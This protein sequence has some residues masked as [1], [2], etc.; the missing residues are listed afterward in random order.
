MKRKRVMNMHYSGS[1]AVPA[2]PQHASGLRYPDSRVVSVQHVAGW[3][4]EG[5]RIARANPVLWLVAILGC[6][7]FVTLFELAPPL[8]VLAVLVGPVLARGRSARQ[9]TLS[10]SIAMR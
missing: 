3:L 6:A 1:T 8:R 10:V 5:F 4:A 7:D 9:S 2:H